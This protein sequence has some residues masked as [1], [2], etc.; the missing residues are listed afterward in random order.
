M[1]LLADAFRPLL[2][3]SATAMTGRPDSISLPDVI[4]SR[5]AAYGIEFDVDSLSVSLNFRDA[6]F[7]ATA[8]A[9]DC[10]RLATASYQSA[11]GVEKVLEDAST[12]PWGL[13]RLYYGAFYS[14]HAMLRLLGHGYCHF[15]AKHSAQ[16]S[17]LASAMGTPI[18][19]AVNAGMHHC[20][21]M[22]EGTSLRCTRASS[23]SSNGSHEAFWTFLEARLRE[24]GDE[25]LEGPLPT[26]DAQ[27]VVGKLESFKRLI[28]HNAAFGWLSKTRNDLQYRQRFDVWFPCGV[29]KSGR[30]AISRLASQW[31]SDPM[32]IDLDA[33][34]EDALARFARACVFQIASCR[35][36]LNHIAQRQPRNRSFLDF[37][38]AGYLKQ[39]GRS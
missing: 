8:T 30:R 18:P 6:D 33:D 24:I 23:S 31:G 27:A 34:M 15:E 9:Y 16:I 32:A 21:V 37:G 7:I 2:V 35:A 11:Q 38:P 4:V 1:S 26:S 17:Q 10:N 13:I 5:R 12:L 39:M 28:G 29:S 25:I 36:L 20:E 14:A 3:S 19:F 22:N